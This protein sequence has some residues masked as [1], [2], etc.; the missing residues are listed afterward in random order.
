M[1]GVTL[2]TLGL[3]SLHF[4]DALQVGILYEVW[5]GFAAQAMAQVASQGDTLYTIEDV[6]RS[7]G[8]VT[9]YEMLNKYGLQPAADNFYYQAR[10]QTD[11]NRGFYCIYKRRDNETGYI[12]DCTNI[13]T[14]LSRHAQQ[15]SAAGVDYLVVD[16]TNLPTLD[17]ESDVIQVWRVSVPS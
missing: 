6:I 5:H 11:V 17:R 12:P 14:T 2:L 7:N 1:R 4:A 13:T 16:A 10:P 9:L 3:A 8:N 15:L